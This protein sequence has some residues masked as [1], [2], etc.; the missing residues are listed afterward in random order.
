MIPRHGS[1]DASEITLD[2]PGPLLQ[3]CSVSSNTSAALTKVEQ[4]VGFSKTELVKVQD[5]LD[6]NGPTTLPPLVAEKMFEQ[7]L[8]GSSLA[9]VAR[10]Y[11]EYSTN[12]VYFTAYHYNWP[13]QRDE[14]ALDIQTRVKQKVLHSKYQQIDLV[15]TM[16]QVAH[17]ETMQAMQMYLKNPNDRNL[18]KTLRIKTI[19]ELSM[20][21]EMMGNIIGQDNNKRIDVTGNI[22]TSPSEPTGNTA[23][24]QVEG[25]LTEATAKALMTSLNKKAKPDPEVIDAEVSK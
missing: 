15:G 12:A 1:L 22:T 6:K 11:S 25:A 13:A 18:P 19:K 3:R 20:A 7:F 8:G 9:E 14:Y 4:K 23:L 5:H 17:T 16:I 21:I 10:F 24:P 2:R